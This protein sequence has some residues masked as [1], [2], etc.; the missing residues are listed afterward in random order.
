MKHTTSSRVKLSLIDRVSEFACGSGSA[1]V[2]PAVDW[3]HC[4]TLS[5]HTHQVVPEGACRHGG[6]RVESLPRRSHKREQLI[7]GLGDDVDQSV[8]VYL[9][10]AVG[11]RRHTIWHLRL[12]ARHVSAAAVE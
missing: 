8:G 2:V 6:Y 4:K 10:S 12:E 7:N 3:G 9:Y 11:S 5:V 1:S